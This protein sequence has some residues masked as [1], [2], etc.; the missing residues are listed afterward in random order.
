MRYIDYYLDLLG[1][2][3]MPYFMKKYLK[4]PSLLRLKNICYF[5]GM[6]Y[7][8]KDI[9]DFKEYVT[10]YD[11]SLSVALITYRFTK[12]KKATLAGLFHDVATPCFAHVIDYM[13]KDY[14]NQESTEEF[15]EKILKSDKYLIKCLKKDKIKIDEI[16]D[17]KKYSI[18]DNKRPKLCAD[19][20]DGV[21][22]TGVNWTKNIEKRDIKNIVKDLCVFINEDYE[23]EIG[24]KTKEVCKKVVEVSESIDVICHSN[25]DN[26]MMQLLA[27]L[28]KFAINNKYIEY[29]DLYY[30][31]EKKVLSIF[32]SIKEKEFIDKYYLFKN[33]KKEEIKTI[34]LPYI[35]KRDLNP[36]ITG[37]RY[38]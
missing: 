10:R 18:V 19:R 8:S 21:V 5:C 23:L 24:F 20:I 26:Y 3:K 33:I 28:T 31:D 4:C 17:F 37:K 29:E 35:K 7:A 36:L 38:S 12:S 34:E 1:Y 15:T 13:N 6:D 2:K 27:D 16:I 25:E 11:H 30:Y 22:L 9:Y 14:A 32:D